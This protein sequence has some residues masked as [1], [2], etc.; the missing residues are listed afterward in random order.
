[1]VF[2]KK[3]ILSNEMIKLMYFGIFAQSA[4][5]SSDLNSHS[6]CLAHLFWFKTNCKCTNIFEQKKTHIN[7]AQKNKKIKQINAENHLCKIRM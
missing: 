5:L 2:I 1:M 4:S 6:T 3:Q 7:K